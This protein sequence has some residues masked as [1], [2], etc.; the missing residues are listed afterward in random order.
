M[1]TYDLFR[2]M[3]ER[4]GSDLHLKVGRPPL[5]RI[6]G[7]LIATEHPPLSS[8]ETR[9]LVYS[10]LHDH[11]T[12]RFE[13]YQELDTA[14]TFEDRARFRINLFYQRGEIGAV[15]RYIPLEI[16]SVEELGLPS[17]LKELALRKQGLLLFTGPTGMSSTSAMSL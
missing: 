15:M 2:E 5:I 14:H 10:I 11:E 9:H 7:E 4:H 3:L 6:H 1:E 17:V 8:D 16:P 12:A 13:A